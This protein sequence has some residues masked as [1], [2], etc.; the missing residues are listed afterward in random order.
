MRDPIHFAARARR[1]LA[2]LLCAVAWLAGC[3][4]GGDA[5]PPAA[6][7]PPFEARTSTQ[8]IGATGGTLQL[9]AADGTLYSLVVAAGA[10]SSDQAISM[11]TVQ[12]AGTSRAAVQFAPTGLRLAQEAVLSVTPPAGAPF[13]AHVQ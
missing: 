12:P 5:P 6:T 7:A 2:V 10:L 3:G 9:S 4:G 8:T 13:A 11:T 1:S